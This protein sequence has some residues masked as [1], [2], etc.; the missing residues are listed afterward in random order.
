[1]APKKRAIGIDIALSRGTERT[2]RGPTHHQVTMRRIVDD[3]RHCYYLIFFIAIIVRC[4]LLQ[5][6]WR[7]AAAAWPVVSLT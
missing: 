7:L 2:K 3:H 4:S 5:R 6:H 1:M